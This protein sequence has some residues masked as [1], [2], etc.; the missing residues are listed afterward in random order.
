MK[1]MSAS[2]LSCIGTL[3]K[4]LCI[5]LFLCLL[6][7]AAANYIE[8]N[9]IYEK[10]P[11]QNASLNSE[12][13]DKNGTKR[14]LEE[15]TALFP[16]ESAEDSSVTLKLCRKDSSVGVFSRDGSLIGELNFSDFAATKKDIE[17]LRNGIILTQNELSELLC[18]LEAELIT[19]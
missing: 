6:F 19:K 9:V 17:L 4:R 13:S 14:S 1:R 12:K 16:P 15:S 8:K 7:A 10:I 11:S 5:L 18:Q 3:V 2:T